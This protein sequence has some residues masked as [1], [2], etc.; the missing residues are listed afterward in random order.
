MP[1]KKPA[2]KARKARDDS[3]VDPSYGIGPYSLS[4]H[5]NPWVP[6]PG[7]HVREILPRK[8]A[9]GGKR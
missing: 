7:T 4:P 8:R 2:K 5:S 6:Y 3:K 1:S 9:K